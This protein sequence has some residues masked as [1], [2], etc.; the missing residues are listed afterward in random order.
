MTVNLGT[1]IN[2]TKE[3]SGNVV[4]PGFEPGSQI[5]GRMP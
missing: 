3:M 1:E 5:T 4:Q 2:A